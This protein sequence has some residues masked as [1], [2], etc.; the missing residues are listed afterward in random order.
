M[1]RLVRWHAIRLVGPGHPL[2][3][4]P[5][6]SCPL[7][8]AYEGCMRG[9]GSAHV[10][11]AQTVCDTAA[12][13]P[14]ARP[15]GLFRE[16]MTAPSGGTARKDYFGRGRTARPLIYCDRRNTSHGHLIALTTHRDWNAGGLRVYP[17]STLALLSTPVPH[18]R[19]V[20]G[21]SL[22]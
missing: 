9:G 4:T 16:G 8:C 22:V 18:T 19:E 6:A 17:P 1:P 10:V 7:R 13:Y 20:V 5:N 3:V 15:Q 11:T 2:V 12:L 21:S 14:P